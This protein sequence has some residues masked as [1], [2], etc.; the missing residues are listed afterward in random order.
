MSSV[1]LQINRRFCVVEQ[2]NRHKQH[3]RPITLFKIKILFPSENLHQKQNYCS[4]D[5]NPTFGIS[6]PKY[7]IFRTITK[8][9]RKH[10]K[11]LL[12]KSKFVNAIL[13]TRNG[14]M[15]DTKINYCC[16]LLKY[17]Q[18]LLSLITVSVSCNIVVDLESN[19]LN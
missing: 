1:Q 7:L 15:T 4:R 9:E 12:L 3:M 19:E 14:I 18:P 11:T 13:K 16:S 5:D 17:L 10:E 8:D 2:F 6:Q